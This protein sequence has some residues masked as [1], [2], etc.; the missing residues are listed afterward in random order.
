MSQGPFL[1]PE[2]PLI[3]YMPLSG[4]VVKLMVETLI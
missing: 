4:A 1:I 3:A 2:H